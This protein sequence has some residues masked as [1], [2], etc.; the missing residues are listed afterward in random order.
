MPPGRTTL[1]CSRL[2]YDTIGTVYDGL[3]FGAVAD[4]VFRDLVVARLAEPTS[5]ADATRVLADLGVET[6]SYKTIQRY[7]TK[8]NTGNY[9]DA[10]AAK[11]FTH[12]ADRA[13]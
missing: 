4:P 7:L 11:C 1:T 13:H 5:K 9:R 12:A 6:V 10:I 8:I 2:F 3:D